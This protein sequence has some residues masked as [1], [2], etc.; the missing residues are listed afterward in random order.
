MVET[1]TLAFQLPFSRLHILL[2][3]FSA[4]FKFCFHILGF[5][6]FNFL[7]WP[8]FSSSFCCHWPL[9]AKLI[10]SRL[11]GI[12]FF[13]AISCQLREFS[14][15]L[16]FCAHTQAA[17][18]QTIIKSITIIISL[19]LSC[20]LHPLIATSQIMPVVANKFKFTAFLHISNIACLSSNN[21]GLRLV[22]VF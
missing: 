12:S 6:D 10:F 3:P 1:T 9:A 14:Q 13:G 8:I 22:C 16:W 5:P 18:Q 19:S 20:H 21:C 4:P 15:L 11:F 7:P 17:Q 2:G